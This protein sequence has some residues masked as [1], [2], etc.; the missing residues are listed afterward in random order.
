MNV[1][2]FGRAQERFWEPFRGTSLSP[3]ASLTPPQLGFNSFRASL[4][5]CF[6]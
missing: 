2:A 1:P 5:P 4:L 6:L 3:G